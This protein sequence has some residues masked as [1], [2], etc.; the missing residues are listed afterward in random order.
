[1]TN[2]PQ[3]EVSSPR[4]TQVADSQNAPGNLV[5][6]HDSLISVGSCDNTSPNSFHKDPL[7]N[8]FSAMKRESQF[9][10]LRIVAMVLIVWS[11]FLPVDT[12][13][14]L[15]PQMRSAMGAIGNSLFFIITGYFSVISFKPQRLLKIFTPVWFYT[16]GYFLLTLMIKGPETFAIL[17]LSDPLSYLQYFLTGN[18]W[19]PIGYAVLYLI[20]HLIVLLYRKLSLALKILV[21]IALIPLGNVLYFQLAIPFARTLFHVELQTQGGVIDY[22]LNSIAYLGCFACG[23]LAYRIDG[24][25]Q[26]VVTIVLMLALILAMTTY[27]LPITLLSNCFAVLLFSLI[28]NLNF[29]NRTVNFIA[30]YVYDI[31]L[32]HV[33]DYIFLGTILGWGSYSFLIWSLKSTWGIVLY[34]LL[35]LIITFSVGII[36][37]VLREHFFK[38]VGKITPKL[39][40]V[41]IPGT[42]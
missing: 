5:L 14:G 17:R 35:V 36:L 20:G 12:Y 41:K 26:V 6:V 28:L 42:K 10:L 16:I 39:T 13:L 34:P 19:F 33:I 25:F 7:P 27:F 38:L 30:K 31:Y 32:T 4:L 1:V 8:G 37:G 29:Y 24:K 18:T 9:E 23:I 22:A 11:H 15:F 3:L 40:G 2:I 21:A